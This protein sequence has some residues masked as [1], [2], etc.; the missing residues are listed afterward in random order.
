MKFGSSI[1]D[2]ELEKIYVHKISR[3]ISSDMY[4]NHGVIN[5]LALVYSYNF[6]CI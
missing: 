2:E 6:D 3:C 4:T 5:H 1:N